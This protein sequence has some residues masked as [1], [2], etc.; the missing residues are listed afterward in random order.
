MAPRRFTVLTGCHQMALD[1]LITG[2]II[3]VW[4]GHWALE[5]RMHLV[6][7]DT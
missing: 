4:N 1:Q 6:H 2:S 3:P 7:K 5:E